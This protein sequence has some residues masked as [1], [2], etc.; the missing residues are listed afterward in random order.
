MI[1]SDLFT[2]APDRAPLHVTVSIGLASRD[3]MSSAEP[4][5]RRAD[6]ALYQS[7]QAGRNCVTAA[8]A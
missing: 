1:E 2:Y 7:K 4:L 8:A 3:G 5:M 6:A